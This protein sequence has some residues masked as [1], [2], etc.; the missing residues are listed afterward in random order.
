MLLQKYYNNCKNMVERNEGRVLMDQYRQFGTWSFLANQPLITGAKSFDR[1][2]AKGFHKDKW[3]RDTIYNFFFEYLRNHCDKIW[4]L[5]IINQLPDFHVSNTDLLDA[6]VSCELFDRDEYK[7]SNKK[8]SVKYKEVSYVTTDERGRRVTKW[9][10]IPIFEVGEEHPV[11]T[12]VAT[13]N[14]RG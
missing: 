5:D 3:N 14:T 2:A 10:K 12:G 9:Q 8:K 4:F 13:W 11:K 7:K 6:L 1:K